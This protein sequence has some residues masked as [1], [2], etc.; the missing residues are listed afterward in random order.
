MC[1]QL[2]RC[3]CSTSSVSLSLSAVELRLKLG[4]G[5]AG[6]RGGIT[7]V[8]GGLGLCMQVFCDMDLF[9]TPWYR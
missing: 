8:S 2:H 6:A 5:G 4:V 9:Q 7:C 1:P 3:A